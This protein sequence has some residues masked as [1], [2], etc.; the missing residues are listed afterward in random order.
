MLNMGTVASHRED[1][2]RTS[3]K[4]PGKPSALL[5]LAQS[6]GNAG[7]DRLPRQDLPDPP[8]AAD[9]VRNHHQVTCALIEILRKHP[10]QGLA[11]PCAGDN[12][13]A[14]GCGR[15]IKEETGRQKKTN[16]NALN[17][18]SS[19]ISLGGQRANGRVVAAIKPQP[20][21]LSNH[22]TAWLN[23]MSENDRR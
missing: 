13:T 20:Q 17:H 12:K 18:D 4:M 2:R 6:P 14:S 9:T 15:G 23:A 22:R 5:I 21:Q 3:K 7:H 19:E 1:N 16:N 8:A 11:V 10:Q